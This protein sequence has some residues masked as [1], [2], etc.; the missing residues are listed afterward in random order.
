MSDEQAAQETVRQ[1]Y[2]ALI[3]KDYKKAG[4]ILG[5]MNDEYV[6]N[7]FKNTNILRIISVGSAER[8]WY[9]VQRGYKVN[10][11]LEII[12]SKGQTVKAMAGPYVRPGDD[13]RHP[14]RWN[15]SGGYDVKEMNPGFEKYKN[16]TPQDVATTFLQ[17]CADEDWQ[18]VK[19]FITNPEVPDWLKNY[20]IVEV[21]SIGEPFKKD[22]Y[23]G[24]YVPYKIRLKSGEVKNFNLALREDN[25]LQIY[26]FDGGL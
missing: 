10:C 22:T 8:Q 12:N 4:L 3:E 9:W 2:Q 24:L 19:I 17:A 18:K 23:V 15:I 20:G 6:I 25:A 16:M 21:L 1:F 14:N 5:G 11:E 26:M 7:N 13:E